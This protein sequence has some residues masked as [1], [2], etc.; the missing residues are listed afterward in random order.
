M[1]SHKRR[2]FARSFVERYGL[3]SEAQARAAVAVEKAIG[4]RKL[5]LI[6]FS[7]TDQH[8][9]LRGKTLVAE[10]ALLALR[11]GVSMTSTLFAK[12][13]SHRTVFPVFDA[14]GGLGVA[15]MGGAGNFVMVADPATFRVLPWAEKTGWVLCDCYFANGVKVP[16]STR[17]LYRDALA[18]LAK[19]G[20]DYLAGLEIEFHLF[21]IDDLRLAPHS[22]E[23]PAEPPAVSHTTHGYQYLTEGRYDQVAPILDVLRQYLT[24]LGL[25]LRSLEVEFGPSQYELT[26]APEMGMA[27]ADAMVLLRSALKQAA[28]RHGYLVSLMCRPGLPHALASGWHLHQSLLDT[29]SKANA[30]ISHDETTPLSPVGRHF[31]AGLLANARAATAFAAPTINGYKRFRGVNT[32]API[33]AV[34]AQDNR[35]VM[36]RVPGEPGDPS[37]HLENRSGEPL[38][39]PYLYMAS[40]I[41]AGLDGIARKLD[42]G[43]S[44]DAPYGHSAEALP[45]TLEEALAAL[46]SNP[47][48]RAGFG[49]RFL[50][51]YAHIKHAEI[52]RC[53]KASAAT[54]NAVDVTDWEHREYFDML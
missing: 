28:R 11:G 23:W 52:V 25:P 42:P 8:G 4:R 13:T 45:E 19:A 34:W 38:A 53:R 15:E 32:M 51:Y 7:F 35:G 12:D 18:K 40:Q 20:F 39:N 47:C 29:R 14:G 31:L 43:A 17:Q 36:V 30:F 44:A 26:F 50:D 6:R 9:V 2:S 5:E 33:Q 16:I 54:P 41:Y 10:E 3:W 49:E 1:A 46:R 21:K 48:F 24:A 37:T 27:P 22:L